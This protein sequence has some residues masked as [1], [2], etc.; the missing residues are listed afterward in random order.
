[1]DLSRHL[2]GGIPFFEWLKLPILSQG[3]SSSSSSRGGIGKSVDSENH[4]FVV[5]N[6]TDHE[7][8]VFFQTQAFKWS[9]TNLSTFR[10]DPETQHFHLYTTFVT[11]WHAFFEYVIKDTL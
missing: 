3:G 11:L 10:K 1:M 4:R 5:E 8:G 6:S 7:G 2:A 9:R